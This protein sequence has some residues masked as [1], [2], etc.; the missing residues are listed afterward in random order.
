MRNATALT[1]VALLLSAGSSCKREQQPS[2][3]AGQLGI[4]LEL[5]VA[6]AGELVEKRTVLVSIDHK[7][8]LYLGA[9]K[10]S[11][12]KLTQ[13]LREA[14][15]DMGQFDVVLHVD[16]RVPHGLVV[17]V[18]DLCR[19]AGITRYSFAVASPRPKEAP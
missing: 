8:V 12:D 2:K 5:P 4:P 3:P 19:R 17:E 16:K 13:Q 18:L 9:A 1:V 7:G 10:T 14:R 11:K 15:R 6:A